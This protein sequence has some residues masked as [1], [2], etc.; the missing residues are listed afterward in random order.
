MAMKLRIDLVI[1]TIQYYVLEEPLLHFD[2]RMTVLTRRRLPWKIASQSIR[3]P[4]L[5]VHGRA[6]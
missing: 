2:L 6:F 5:S 1:E 3:G 4:R